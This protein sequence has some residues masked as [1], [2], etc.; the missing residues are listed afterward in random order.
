M[1]LKTISARQRLALG[2]LFLSIV[3]IGVFTLPLEQ[4]L[5]QAQAWQKERPLV[6]AMAYIAIVA[7][8]TPLMLP[9]SVLMMSAGFLFG[10][11]HGALLAAVGVTLGATSGVPRRTQ[12]R[13]PGRGAVHREQSAI[14]GS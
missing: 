7:V 12:Y 4:W 8:A 3:L 13:A 9:G 6:A 10:A 2:G 5:E 14:S 11:V 1:N